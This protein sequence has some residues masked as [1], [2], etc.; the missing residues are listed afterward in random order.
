MRLCAPKKATKK[1]IKEMPDDSIP[2]ITKILIQNGS[3]TSRIY[4]SVEL[5]K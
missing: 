1:M 3:V 4:L 5:S 2:I